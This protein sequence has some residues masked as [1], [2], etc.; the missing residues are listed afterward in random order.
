MQGNTSA[1][2][3]LRQG[4]PF[5]VAHKMKFVI[6]YESQT[7][8]METVDLII[9]NV[10]MTHPYHW[11]LTKLRQEECFFQVFNSFEKMIKDEKIYE[12]LKL[13]SLS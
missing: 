4:E 10:T 1:V 7:P 12:F 2:Y 6:V 5:P 9:Y 11:L 3:V 8:F 13:I